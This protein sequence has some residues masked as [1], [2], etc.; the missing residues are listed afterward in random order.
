MP[1]PSRK[2]EE[3]YGVDRYTVVAV[4]GIESHYGVALDNPKLVKNTIRSLATLAYSGGA[5][6]SSGASSS[7]R[8]SASFSAA[9]FRSRA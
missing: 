5:S 7:S 3:R 8:R 9:T 1:I 6:A 2:I 4:W